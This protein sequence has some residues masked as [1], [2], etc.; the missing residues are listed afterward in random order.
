MNQGACVGFQRKALPRASDASI[1]RGG[2]SWAMSMCAISL[3]AR[4]Q[5]IR[6]EKAMSNIC[7]NEALCALRA[8]MYLSQPMI[9]R[10]FCALQ[11][12]MKSIMP[13]ITP[14]SVMAS[15]GMPS[16][17]ARLQSGSRWQAPSSMLYLV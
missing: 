9:G 13:Y 11:A 16:S 3:Q 10:M 4:E 5:H 8:L 1:K 2:F 17:A 12:L 14:W 7:T 6:R 15:A